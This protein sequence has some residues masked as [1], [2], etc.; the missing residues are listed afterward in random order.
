MLPDVQGK[1]GGILRQTSTK[2]D[3]VEFEIEDNG[4]ISQITSRGKFLEFIQRGADRDDK[5]KIIFENKK[6]KLF[7]GFVA[8]NTEKLYEATKL[9]S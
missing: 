1:P 9:Q 6:I 5:G 8:Q 7:R 4:N 2:A 3:N